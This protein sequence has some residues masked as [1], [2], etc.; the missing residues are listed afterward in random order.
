VA[1]Y[2][3][4]SLANCGDGANPAQATNGDLY[5]T[6]GSDGTNNGGTVFSLSLGLGPFVESLPT[7][8]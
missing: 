8:G 7:A 2:S 4:C 3:F 1:R 6:T 5:G